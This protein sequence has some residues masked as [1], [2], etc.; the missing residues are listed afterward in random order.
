VANKRYVLDESVVKGALERC[1]PSL[2]AI[3]RIVNRCD[4]IVFNSDWWDKC[5]ACMARSAGSEVGLRLLRV[6]NQAFVVRDKLVQETAEGEP[7][8][9]ENGIH[10]KD[11]W[12]VR[13]AVSSKATLVTKDG[14]L[15]AALKDKGVPCVAPEDVV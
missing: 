4:S 14:P 5:Y 2:E 15:A 13:L 9:D 6:F 3:L 8:K 11:L 7:L 1:V 10:H 12:V